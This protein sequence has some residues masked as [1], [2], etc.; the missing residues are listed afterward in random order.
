MRRRFVRRRRSVNIK[1]SLTRDRISGR[2]R[3]PRRRSTRAVSQPS[4]RVKRRKRQNEQK[5]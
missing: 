3:P 1:R 4:L 2:T 5:G